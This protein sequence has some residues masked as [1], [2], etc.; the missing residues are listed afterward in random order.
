MAN[1]AKWLIRSYRSYRCPDKDYEKAAYAAVAATTSLG[2]AV[3]MTAASNV[4]T[5]RTKTEVVSNVVSWVEC[6]VIINKGT[7][8]AKPPNS[9]IPRF[10]KYRI[11]CFS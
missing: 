8:K 9:T 6:K 2:S 4:A 1:S 5:T 7:I 11:C 3:S 10:D